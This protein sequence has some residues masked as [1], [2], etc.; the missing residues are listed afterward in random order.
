MH[1]RCI[2]AAVLAALFATQVAKADW[3]YESSRLTEVVANGETPW[4]FNCTLDSATGDITL[5]SVNQKGGNP[6]LD[7]NAP[8]VGGHVIRHMTANTTSLF[9]SR[10][11]GFADEIILP[12]TLTE[13][14]GWSFQDCKNPITIPP[15][16]ALVTLETGCFYNSYLTG[17]I[18]L[19]CVTTMNG[20]DG[21]GPFQSCS[22]MTSLD[23][24]PNITGTASYGNLTKNCTALTSLVVRASSFTISGYS[25]ENCK[26][27]RQW[28]F[29]CYP[30]LNSNWASGVT[31]GK[32]HRIFV[33]PRNTQW[34][35]VINSVAFTP[36]E[37]ADQA[38]YAA[39]FG[40]DAQTPLGYT[41]TPFAAYLLAMD[42]GASAGATVVVEASPANYGAVSPG[43]GEHADIADAVTFTASQYSPDGAVLHECYGY[44]TSRW[45][46]V[47]LAWCDGT[48][49]SNRTFTFEP[50]GGETVK[51]TWL[52]RDA[53]YA[54]TYDGLLDGCSLTTNALDLL[55]G[56]ARKGS[57]VSLTAS[58]ANF[59]AWYNLPANAVVDG[60]TATFP[61]GAPAELHA[62]FAWPW[63]YDA[64]AGTISDRYWTL[65]VSASGKDLTLNSVAVAAKNLLDLNKKVLD[66]YK[67]RRIPDAP[68]STALFKSRG[69]G[70]ADEIILP[71]TLTSVGSWSFQDCK[72]PI[73]I[74][75]DNEIVTLETG[76]F[77]A[78][79]L[80]G[81]VVLPCVTTMNGG[82]N[83]G[84][85]NKCARMTLLDLGTGIT[86]TASSGNLTKNCTA[87]TSLVI[88]ASSFTISGYSM[89]NCT[90]M[91]N[92]IFHCY[93]TLAN[94]WA[95]GVTFGKKHR[96]FM[97][98]DQPEWR[99]I[100]ESAS[101]TPW[102]NADQSSYYANFGADAPKPLGYTTAPFAAYLLPL[103]HRATVILLQ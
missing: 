6:I 17:D 19:P 90:A 76:C 16:N 88:R 34:S 99:T 50:E 36:W 45:D 35:E 68:S 10:A 96:I 21:Q 52:W 60:A 98:P 83:A 44:F 40:N 69:A 33:D 2:F 12:A 53:G 24:G 49:I 46:E 75:P 37:S 100:I 5:T 66:G 61:I 81:D 67:I 86:G 80:T 13:V 4:V 32:K 22:R 38:S 72:N 8:V 82:D 87:L 102:R 62:Y 57:V 65:R 47:N 9:K 51:I 95:N 39:N 25:M 59:Q 7:L 70:F 84:P 58:G 73:T 91:R 78:S 79:Y 14:G 56:Y 42:A 89:E 30:T 31:F 29:Y 85:F 54:V 26:A 23:L 101:F 74:P 3:S 92:W 71:A 15:D 97:D 20:R 27:M 18:V 43:Y 77:Y 11:A 55:E 64:A 93:P 63:V 103:R 41:T 1:T 28:T 94:K 48:V